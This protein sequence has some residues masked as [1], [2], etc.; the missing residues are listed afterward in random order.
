MSKS[1]SPNKPSAIVQSS[2]SSPDVPPV[3]NDPDETPMSPFW[4]LETGSAKKLGQHST[5]QLHYQ[6]LA[7]HDRCN[8]FHRAHEK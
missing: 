2:T 6:V 3:S 5:G 8:L 4:L 7:D 1:A